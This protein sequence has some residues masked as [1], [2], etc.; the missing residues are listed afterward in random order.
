MIEDEVIEYELKIPN[1][2]VK[3]SLSKYIISKYINDDYPNEKTKLLKK[4]LR[5]AD[6]DFLC[7]LS[8]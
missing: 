7:T 2:E 4:A 6:L 5:E 8:Q 1:K 3:I